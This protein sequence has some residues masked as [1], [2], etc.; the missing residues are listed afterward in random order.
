MPQDR[1]GANIAPKRR[2]RAAPQENATNLHTSEPRLPLWSRPGFLLRRLNQIHYALFLEECSRYNITPVQYGLLT[3]LSIRGHL[4]QSSLA[5]EL[6]L[7]RTNIA[8][9][10][11]RLETRGLVKRSQDIKD[12]RVRIAKITAKG[13]DITAR[14]FP[15]MQ[16]SQDRLLAP[17][18]QP[19][20][21]KFMATLVRLIEANNAYGRAT[22]NMD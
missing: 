18:T 15:S 5:A 11:R 14:M 17:L 10:L 20:R 4:D 6:G 2:R 16:R 1:M 21:D 7:D 22:L 13:R 9:V 8:D 3:A 19:E 12:R